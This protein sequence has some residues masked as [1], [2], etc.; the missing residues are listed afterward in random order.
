MDTCTRKE[1]DVL[2]IELKGK[3][4]SNTSTSVQDELVKFVKD[5][6]SKL[7]LNLKNLEYMSCAGL[8]V[9]LIMSKLVHNQQGELRLCMAN[10]I[11]KC[12]INISGFDDLLDILDTEQNAIDS[13]IG[14]Y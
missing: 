6:E 3:L 5:G 13:M 8:R 11:V 9:I 2:I 4:N 7:I 14:I 1:D 10:E 12:V